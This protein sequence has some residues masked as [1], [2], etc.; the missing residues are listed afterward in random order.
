MPLGHL[1]SIGFQITHLHPERI[2]I[3]QLLILE[4]PAWE[5]L[6]SHWLLRECSEEPISNLVQ[7]NVLHDVGIPE[8]PLVCPVIKESLTCLLLEIGIA[9]S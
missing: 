2:Y 6:H 8:V 7:S 1:G 9:E 3:L 4:E 5:F